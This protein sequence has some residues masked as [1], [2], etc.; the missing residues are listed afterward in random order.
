MS[1]VSTKSSTLS[2]VV[3]C[4]FA[5]S[6]QFSQAAPHNKLTLGVVANQEDFHDGGC[7]LLA[8]SDSSFRLERYIFMS[9]FDGHAVMNIDGHDIQ[10]ALVRSEEDRTQTKKGD[11]SKFWY[12]SG[13]INVEVD[14]TVTSE[15]PPDNESCEVFGYRA[16]IH[17]VS[18]SKKRSV[19]AHGI[20]G[21]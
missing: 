1:S 15:C 17:V 21:V 11:R 20:C 2:A 19:A 3:L 6:V 5:L 13:P 12:A 14:Y 8:S 16:I 4:L 7:Q 10:L 9:D 18:R